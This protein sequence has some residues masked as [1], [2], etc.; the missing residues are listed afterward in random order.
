MIHDKSGKRRAV[1]T[2][3]K[4]FLT[5]QV[6]LK[7]LGHW[8]TYYANNTSLTL[9]QYVAEIAK[10]AGIKDRRSGMLLNLSKAMNSPIA[11][12]LPEPKVSEQTRDR[13]PSIATTHMF[14][15][16][17]KGLMNLMP[18]ASQRS[19]FYDVL[20]SVNRQ[21]VAQHLVDALV[22]W[23]EK[24]EDLI[25]QPASPNALRALVNRT[26]VVMCERLGP[27]DADR[28]LAQAVNHCGRDFP[29]WSEELTGLL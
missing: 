29:Q 27:V 14:V 22:Q 7:A 28:L 20:E 4:P 19:V 23:I 17:M 26:Y 5:E 25:L 13:L 8:D 3:L 21:R 1:Y 18:P 6:L 9:Q 24:E 16:L 2:A 11:L 10:G 15:A 12:L